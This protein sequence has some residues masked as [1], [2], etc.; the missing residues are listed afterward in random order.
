MFT[1]YY[2]D[3][4]FLRGD[5]PGGRAVCRCDAGGVR[6]GELVEDGKTGPEDGEVGVRAHDD[7][8]L[9]LRG[10]RGSAKQCASITFRPYKFNFYSENNEKTGSSSL[11]GHAI[12]G[13]RSS[14]LS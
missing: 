12:F 2:V 11:N 3:L 7:E 4:A 1:S 9:F 8:R 14:M 6:D 10:D 13:R 5:H